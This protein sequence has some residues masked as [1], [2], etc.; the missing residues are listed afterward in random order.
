MCLSLLAVIEVNKKDIVFLIDGST[1]LGAGPFNVIRD[2]VAKIVQ[3]LEVGPDLIQV[4]V[5]QYADTVKPEFYFNTHQNRKDVMANVRKM[6]LMG[7]T[8]LN[9]GSA[10]DFVRNNFFTSAAGCRMEEGVL[11]MLVLITGGK[12]RDA[13]DQPVAEMKRNRIVTLAVGSRNA[14]PAELQEIAHERDFVFQPNDFRLQ[15]MQAILP[16]VLSP[17]RTLSGGMIV[18]EPPS[19]NQLPCSSK[20]DMVYDF[21]NSYFFTCKDNKKKHE[22]RVST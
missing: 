18:Q 1:A 12:S 4:A 22:V 5:A 9:T 10:L 17:I 19:G 15:F 2:F 16:E 13:V 7:G 3:R 11:P 6:K 21:V 20:G 8:A 14:D